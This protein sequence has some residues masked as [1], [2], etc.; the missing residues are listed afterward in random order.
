MRINEIKVETANIIVRTVNEDDY[1]RFVWSYQNALPS[2]NRFD[3]GVLE[4]ASFMT[5]EWFKALIMRREKEA[6]ADECY[7]FGVFRKSDGAFL[8]SCDIVTQYR[9]DIQYAKIGY[10]LHNIY[11]NKGYGTETVSLLLKVGF[12]LLGFHRLEAHVNLDNIASQ[13]VLLKAGFIYEGIR[14]G[15]ILEDDVWTDN[16]IYYKNKC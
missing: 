13:R 16:Q 10:E 15:F 11:W 1:D 3:D 7:M 14:K 2:Q 12:E 9:E 4:D 5:K 6:D 8:G